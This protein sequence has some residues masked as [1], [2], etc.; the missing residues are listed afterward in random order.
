MRILALSLFLFLSP[1][2]ARYIISPGTPDAATSISFS[3]ASGI[4]DFQPPLN[5]SI[6]STE[7]TLNSSSAH[8]LESSSSDETQL[9]LQ[10]QLQKR[11]CRPD[12]AIAS[13]RL[14][15][16]DSMEAF[17][18]QLLLREPRELEWHVQ[19]CPYLLTDKPFGF[20]FTHPCERFN[21]GF[22][23]YHPGGRNDSR[24]LGRIVG[25]FWDDLQETSCGREQAEVQ[26]LR[27]TKDVEEFDL[28]SN[29]VHYDVLTTTDD[30]ATRQKK[31]IYAAWLYMSIFII[32][33][34]LKAF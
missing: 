15:L 12:C 9:H 17:Q 19:G 32:C 10:L 6:T 3:P 5:S 31:C 30:A 14:L 18:R 27:S 11:E 1:V 28:S 20:D 24:V 8:P 22:W 21:F 25:Q 16:T 23:N 34:E 33:P 26:N 29:E 2:A 13:T 7:M 4:S